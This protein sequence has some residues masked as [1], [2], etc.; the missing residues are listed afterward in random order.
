MPF[1]NYKCFNKYIYIY[2]RRA[3]KRLKGENN[4]FL[5]ISWLLFAFGFLFH[6]YNISLYHIPL[7]TMKSVSSARI[8][9]TIAMVTMAATSVVGAGESS[10]SSVVAKSVEA[11]T[12]SIAELPASSVPI[13]VSSTISPPVLVPQS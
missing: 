7:Y 5:S 9:G 1:G 8:I 13:S 3:D 2:A 11:E 4:R 6:I 10:I 12:F